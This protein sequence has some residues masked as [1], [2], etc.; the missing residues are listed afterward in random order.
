M[1]K[2]KIVVAGNILAIPLIA[3]ACLSSN[4]WLAM[5]AFALK[6]AVS[7]SYL[8]PAITMMQNSSGTKNAGMVVS[9]YTFYSHI[10]QTIAPAMFGFLAKYYGAFKVP[11]VYGKLITGFVICGYLISSIF[12]MRAG[13]AYTKLMEARNK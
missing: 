12:Y 1:T 9:A 10:A 13:R 7:G 2:A 3:V 6:I 8:A 5:T 4:F 11:Q